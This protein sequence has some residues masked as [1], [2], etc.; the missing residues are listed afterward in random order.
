[1]RKICIKAICLRM[2]I[3]FALA[4]TRS[5]VLHRML[6]RFAQLICPLNNVE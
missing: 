5:F 1:M 6:C 3:L 4:K 2:N